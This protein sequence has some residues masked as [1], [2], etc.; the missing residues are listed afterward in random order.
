M[1]RKGPS[2]VPLVDYL[3]L[4]ERPHLRSNECVDCGARF[5]DRRN[6]C[7][8]CG[9]TEF[10]SAPVEN[11]GVVRAFTI[12]HRAAPDILAP[13]VSAIIETE[14]G[15]SVR[16]NVVNCDPTPEAVTLG[17]S[18]RLVVYPIGRDDN[19]TEAI[20]FGYEPT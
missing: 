19:G 2:Q 13:Y 8:S 10:R 15:T 1:T 7:A 16:S 20:A 6:G 5:F 17:M 18:V 9:G 12:V 4:G 3:R 14:D 11:R